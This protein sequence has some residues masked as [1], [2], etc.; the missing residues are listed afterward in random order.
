MT[1][2]VDSGTVAHAVEIVICIT[3]SMHTFTFFNSQE[4]LKDN[5]IELTTMNSKSSQL[6]F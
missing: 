6:V 2:L 4:M 5:L 1:F 3:Q